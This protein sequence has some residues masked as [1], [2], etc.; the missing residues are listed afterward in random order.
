MKN[1]KQDGFAIIFA[2]VIMVSVTA[3][4]I[5]LM[6][7]S[8]IDSLVGRVTV[9]R[10]QAEHISES[11]H[12]VALFENVNRTVSEGTAVGATPNEIGAGRNLFAL[13]L[14]T[15]ALMPF[16]EQIQVAVRNRY[17]EAGNTTFRLE[18]RTENGVATTCPFDDTPSSAEKIK[19]VYVE[20]T[21]ETEYGPFN[22]IHDIQIVTG[23]SQEVKY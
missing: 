11:S 17:P 15:E 1:I 5:A 9:D 19:C 16:A 8:T 18:S 7:N 13:P 12:S 22:N 2:L 23:I 4:G 14:S 20:M 10:M 21:S 3:L 6:S